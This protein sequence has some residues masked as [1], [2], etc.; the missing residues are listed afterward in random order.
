MYVMV[1]LLNSFHALSYWDKTTV[2]CN[3]TLVSYPLQFMGSLLYWLTQKPT[4]SL[5]MHMYSYISYT[6]PKCVYVCVCVCVCV[7]VY[8]C[9]A[10]LFLSCLVV[11]GHC[12]TLG[13]AI[14]SVRPGQPSCR[15]LALP[16]EDLPHK[17]W[18]PE[19]CQ[20]SQCFITGQQ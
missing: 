11:W 5:L 18:V 17:A 19:W 20:A 6:P 16:Q 9:N 8:V 7:Y 10:Q 4:D 13:S 14:L 15:I 2:Q 1:A 3:F 12:G